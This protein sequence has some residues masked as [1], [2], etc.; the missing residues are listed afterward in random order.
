MTDCKPK[1][2][3]MDSKVKLEPN[4]N[5]ANKEEI[6]YFQQIIGY[7]LFLILATKPDIC[8]AV[9]KL[10]RFASNLSVGHLIAL[11]N[12]LR[13][14][15]GLKKL[16]LIYE[17]SPNKYASGYYNADYAG[18][19]GTAKST[20]GISFYLA[21]CLISWKSKLQSVI[22]Q[23]TTKAEYITINLAYKEAVYIK[24]L[25]AE[26]GYY[27]QEQ[28]PIYTNN[29]GA[30]LLGHN[31]QFH[32]RT[33]HIAV[34]YHYV[35]DLINKGEIDLIFIKGFIQ[36]ANGFTKPLDKPKFIEFIRHLRLA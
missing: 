11:K 12:V 26:L 14:L 13:Y 2:T 16:G 28:F 29:N 24:Q 27:I 8:Y 15:K 18:D 22:T 9:I 4:P 5:Q 10:A 19:I 31:S 21:S 23:S 20:S 32:E 36:K 17:K 34:K 1:D 6:N 25:L 33:K 7:L 30:L 35:R 3:P